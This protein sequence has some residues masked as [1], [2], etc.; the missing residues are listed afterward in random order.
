MKIEEI[1]EFA[2]KV[3]QETILRIRELSKKGDFES[4][5]ELSGCADG[6]EF[7]LNQFKKLISK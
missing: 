7:R 3:K 5:K 6:I 2:E 4:I 1:D